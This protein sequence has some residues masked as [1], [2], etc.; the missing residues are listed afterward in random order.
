[1]VLDSI[2]CQCTATAEVLQG[3]AVVMV[4]CLRWELLFP[5]L[6]PPDDEMKDA[7]GKEWGGKCK[8][9]RIDVPEL[10]L[11][12]WALIEKHVCNQ[13]IYKPRNSRQNDEYA[14]WQMPTPGN[15]GN[16]ECEANAV[17]TPWKPDQK[18]SCQGDDS[19]RPA[20]GTGLSLYIHAVRRRI[21]ISTDSHLIPILSTDSVFLLLREM[22]RHY[23]TQPQL[24]YGEELSGRT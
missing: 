21:P 10:I 19:C 23:T 22:L 12:R 4:L 13:H 5:L 17:Y 3:V 15:Y 9:K 11:A 16:Q 8:E 1:M 18:R 20:Q 2:P 14:A 7:A 24:G 6:L